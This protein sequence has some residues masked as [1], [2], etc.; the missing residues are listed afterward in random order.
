[1]ELIPG[2]LNHEGFTSYFYVSGAINAARD[3]APRCFATILYGKTAFMGLE[4]S[5]SA[6]FFWIP[7]V[8]SIVGGSLAGIMYLLFIQA[9]W[10]EESPARQQAERRVMRTESIA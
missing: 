1:M 3:F 10:Q 9:H 2:K 5:N 4:N 7:L 8:G 6:N